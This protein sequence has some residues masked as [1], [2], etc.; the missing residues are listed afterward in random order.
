M[1]AADQSTSFTLTFRHGV[2][3]DLE[4]RGARTYEHARQLAEQAVPNSAYDVTDGASP[5]AQVAAIYV[6]RDEAHL[7]E[8]H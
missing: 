1:I 8:I 7:P 3:I 6:W 5:D 2:K 4:V